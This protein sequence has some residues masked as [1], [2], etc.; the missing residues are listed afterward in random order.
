MECTVKQDLIN[1]ENSIDVT[2]KLTYRNFNTVMFYNEDGEAIGSLRFSLKSIHLTGCIACQTP[3]VLAKA[4]RLSAAEGT[5]DW[6]VSLKD[7]ILDIKISGQVLYRHELKGECKEIYS[8]A[9]RFAFTDMVCSSTF[10]VHDDMDLG[11]RMN[12]DCAGDCA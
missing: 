9:M 11:T 10:I 6:S 12:E 3:A 1:T 5:N 2:S 8:K 7:A 4:A